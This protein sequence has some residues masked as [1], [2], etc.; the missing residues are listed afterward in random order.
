MY[1]RPTKDLKLLSDGNVAYTPLGLGY[2][3]TMAT[4]SRNYK[5]NPMI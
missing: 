1:E 2:L 3:P 5:N 4:A